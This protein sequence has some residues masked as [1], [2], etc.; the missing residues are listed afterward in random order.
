MIQHEHAV[1]FDFHTA[2]DSSPKT[3]SLRKTR[4]YAISRFATPKPPARSALSMSTR[5]AMCSN[6]AAALAK[7]SGASGGRRGGAD[8]STA[9]C[10]L[11]ISRGALA[12]HF[13]AHGVALVEAA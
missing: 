5:R 10:V 1:N 4:P 11:P 3:Q 9:M 13:A 2:K 7:S 12:H 6:R 8:T